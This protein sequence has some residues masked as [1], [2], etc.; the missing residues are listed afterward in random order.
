[1]SLART[2]VCGARRGDAFAGSPRG[3]RKK[4]SLAIVDPPSNAVVGRVRTGDG[5]HECV[6]S[7]DGKLAFVSNYGD[8]TPGNSL[9]VIDLIE[10]KEL[11]RV[12]LGVLRRPHG[13]FFA[14]GKLYFTAELNQ[15]IGNLRPCD[16]PKWTGCS[17]TGQKHTHMIAVAPT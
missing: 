8:A 5:P 15:I 12:D 11:H 4:G 16:E 2:G 14:G 7:S 9:S 10:R 13:L 1:M 3:Q 17:E 6:A